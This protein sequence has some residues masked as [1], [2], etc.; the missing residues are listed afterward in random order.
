MPEGRV[1]TSTLKCL[2]LLEAVASSPG[3]IGVSELARMQGAGRGTVHQQL[4]TL[5]EAGWVERVEGGRYRL[6][7]KATQI[8]HHAL[9]Q[10]NLGERIRPALE[11]LAAST[12]E[13]VSL[14]VLDGIDV[15]IVQRVESG[16]ILRAGLGVGTHM[17]LSTSASGRVLLAFLPQTALDGLRLKGV[18][19]PSEEALQ[20]VRTS[21][22]AVSVDEFIEGIAAVSAPLFDATG[23]VIAALSTACPTTRF[24]EAVAVP[25]V[26]RAAAEVNAL[27]RGESGWSPVR[28]TATAAALRHALSG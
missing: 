13:A 7:L 8:G 2:A 18:A 11:A 15:L 12:G 9:E 26:I 1:L 17:P 27:L 23:A 5:V 3:A 14:G 10:A 28:S 19:F 16:Q 21:E 6:T 22:V 20:K 24:S 25:A 4:S